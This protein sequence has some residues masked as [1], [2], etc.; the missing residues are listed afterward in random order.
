M[1]LRPWL[2]G[3]PPTL[4][5]EPRERV[6]AARYP[7]RVPTERPDAASQLPRRWH[8][9]K[10][11]HDARVVLEEIKAAILAPT[12][13]GDAPTPSEI[14]VRLG[15]FKSLIKTA[16]RGELAD[17]GWCAVARDPLL[18]EL[19]WRWSASALMRG[20]FHEPATPSHLAVLAKVHVKEVVFGDD[21]ATRRLQNMQIDEASTR[22]TFGRPYTWGLGTSEPLVH[23]GPA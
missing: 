3:V 9:L 20:Y 14:Q 4:L 6:G 10:E 13:S 2:V 12:P 21:P 7:D 8:P 1:G 5:H 18:W 19:R 11:P 15:E 17:E 23:S 16:Q 22:I